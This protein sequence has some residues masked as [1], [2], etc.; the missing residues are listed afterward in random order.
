MTQICRGIE[1]L[2]AAW[3]LAGTSISSV[4]GS[5]LK[6]HVFAASG[7]WMKLF[8]FPLT[9]DE[10]FSSFIHDHG[11]SHR[12]VDVTSVHDVSSFSQ[13]D[14]ASVS[15]SLFALPYIHSIR[16][17]RLIGSL[18]RNFSVAIIRSKEFVV[19]VEVLC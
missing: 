6:S 18:S 16:C 4:S 12:Y 15:Q 8:L 17:E 14:L 10:I 11:S 3:H 9:F 13:K 19:D 5:S 1:E 7:S 2:F